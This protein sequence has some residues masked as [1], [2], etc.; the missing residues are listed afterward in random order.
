MRGWVDG[1]ATSEGG[2]EVESGRV[3]VKGRGMRYDPNN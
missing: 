3:V 1:D 2:G